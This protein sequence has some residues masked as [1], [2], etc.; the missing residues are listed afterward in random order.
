VNAGRSSRL[1]LDTIPANRRLVEEL[2]SN[3]LVEKA[4]RDHALQFLHPYK[5]WGPWV[6]RLLLVIGVSLILAGIIYF[7]AFN[8]AKIPPAIKLGSVELGIA[9]CAVAA[10]VCG[11]D[12]FSGKVALLSACV[13]VGVFLAV[14]GQIYQTGAD[15]YNL[16][17]TWS[18]LIAG[19]V[20]IAEFAPLWAV[21][22]V[23]T[24]IFLLLYWDQAA[25]PDREME[26]MITSILAVF[27][28]AFLGLREYSV[29]K[30]VAWLSESWTRVVLVIPILV[31]LLIPTLIY[32]AEPSHATS[33]IMLGALLGIV[34]HAGLFVLYRH[35]LPDMWALSAV[36]LSGCIILEVAGFKLL[37][38]VFGNGEAAL[39][40]L[41]GLMT[42]GIFAFAITALRVITRQL[43]APHAG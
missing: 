37:S 6:S 32:I 33:S 26:M 27:N 34:I 4:A 10:Y 12:R 35:E 13:L 19:W 2:F 3:G 15:A 41:A 11:L 17:M 39:Y 23:V 14:F 16:F 18:V 28:L 9:I 24:N 29:Q 8:W 42:I 38:E 20:I 40:L 22:L 30:A 21:W 43:G 7:F 1:A 25:L 31:L 36:F 5:G